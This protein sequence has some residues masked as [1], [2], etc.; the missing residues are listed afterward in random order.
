MENYDDYLLILRKDQ[1][2][3]IMQNLNSID[4]DL[5]K[6]NT[7]SESLLKDITNKRRLKNI[8]TTFK[9]TYLI[10]KSLLSKRI[11]KQIEQ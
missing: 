10:N 3:D 2:D 4:T 7:T 9:N 11:L 5:T 8:H 1:Y 6:A